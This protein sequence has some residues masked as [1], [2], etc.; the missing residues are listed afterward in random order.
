[1]RDFAASGL[2][3][4]MTALGPVSAASWAKAGSVLQQ[5]LKDKTKQEQDSYTAERT[6]LQLTQDKLILFKTTHINALNDMASVRTWRYPFQTINF[7]GISIRNPDIIIADVGKGASVPPL[8]IG[9]GA[10][11]QLHLFIAYAEKVLYLT[12]AEAH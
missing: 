2:G 11:R 6:Q 12:A 8:T 4:V 7:E 1:M 5:A 9:I 10:L 3:D